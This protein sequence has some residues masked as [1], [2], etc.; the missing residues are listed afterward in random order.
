[1]PEIYSPI[2][3]NGVGNQIYLAKIPSSMADALF[4]IAGDTARAIEQDLSSDIKYEIPTNETE[5][6]TDI[7]MRTDIGPTQKTQIINSR[8]G[9]GVFKSNVRLIE[10]ACRVTGV[11]NPRH[12]IASHIKPWSKSDDIEKLS[13]FNGLLLSP[14][15]DHLF[16]KGFIS[17]EESGNLVLS[18]KLETETLEKWQINKDINVGSFKQEQKQFLEY[19]RD[20]V[21][22]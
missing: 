19:H 16:D 1:L 17:F 10:T 3:P 18:N 11:A 6:E 5:E 12:L 7:Q 20:M 4:G 2:R 13:G 8:R 15:I 14:H 21:L 22:I 9:Q